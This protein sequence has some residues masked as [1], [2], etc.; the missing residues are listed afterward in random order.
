MKEKKNEKASRQKNWGGGSETSR[1]LLGETK[2]HASDNGQGCENSGNEE[3]LRETPGKITQKQYF[4][5]LHKRHGRMGRV[6][7]ESLC[8]QKTLAREKPYQC[9]GCEESSSQSRPGSPQPGDT[10]SGR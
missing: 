9:K 7:A 6:L 4:C 8:H 1:T 3:M 2:Q 10:P 5:C